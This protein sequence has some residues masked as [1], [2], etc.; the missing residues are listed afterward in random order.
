M[1]LADG[2]RGKVGTH[3]KKREH[4]KTKEKITKQ[5]KKCKEGLIFNCEKIAP[6]NP[7]VKK[8]KLQKE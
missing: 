5:K 3:T 2:W 1:Q 8:P 6:N 7:A 4:N